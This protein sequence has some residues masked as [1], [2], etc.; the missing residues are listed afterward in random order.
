M[1]SS[2]RKTAAQNTRNASELEILSSTAPVDDANEDQIT[3]I[4]IE[5][6]YQRED[7][8]SEEPNSSATKIQLMTNDKNDTNSEC[9]TPISTKHMTSILPLS[10]TE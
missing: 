4:E 6:W 3:G 7:A 5:N 8:N 10:P 9:R 2:R 1:S